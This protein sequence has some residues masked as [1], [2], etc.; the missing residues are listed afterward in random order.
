M[1]RGV[2]PKIASTAGCLSRQK[3]AGGSCT[4]TID[5]IAANTSAAKPLHTTRRSRA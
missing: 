2:L 3:S 4:M 5:M 1:M